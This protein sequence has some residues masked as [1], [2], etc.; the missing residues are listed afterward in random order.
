MAEPRDPLADILA[1]APPLKAGGDPLA[2]ILAAAPSLRPAPPLPPVSAPSI[3]PKAAPTAPPMMSST[4]DPFAPKQD[5]LPSKP[6]PAPQLKPST[7]AAPEDAVVPQAPGKIPQTV[8]MS[9]IGQT[10]APIPGKIP[11]MELL[12]GVAPGVPTKPR[13]IGEVSA[14]SLAG[15]MAG[16]FVR[17]AG[18]AAM[19]VPRVL[20]RIPGGFRDDLE[21][22]RPTPPNQEFIGAEAR[23]AEDA[24]NRQ[25]MARMI[26]RAE[27]SALPAAPLT[28]PGKFA[29]ALGSTAPYIAA[30]AVGGNAATGALGVAAGVDEAMTRADMSGKPI[31][32][33]QRAMIG[34]GGAAIGSTEALPFARL[35][36]KLKGAGVVAEA[37]DDAGIVKQLFPG[38]K[39]YLTSAGKQGLEEGAQEGFSNLAQDAMEASYGARA[40]EKIGQDFFENAGTGGAVGV[41]IDAL[42]TLAG[43]RA[44]R[45]R[46]RQSG[47]DP[48][49]FRAWAEQQNQ[50]KQ[51]AVADV[52]G[53]PVEAAQ[54][55]PA[56]AP[57]V[58][59]PEASPAVAPQPDPLQQAI[60]SAPPLPQ[61][62]KPEA[63]APV[64]PPVQQV[65]PPQPEAAV[66]EDKPTVQPS[67]NPGELP[68]APIPAPGPREEVVQPKPAEA[69]APVAEGTNRGLNI[70]KGRDLGVD[71]LHGTSPEGKAAIEESGIFDP[72]KA[73][74]HYDY[75]EFGFG[76]SYFAK[77]ESW[78]VQNPENGRAI[79]YK[80]SVEASLDPDANIVVLRNID[81]ADALARSFGFES[82]AKLYFGG[83]ALD[84]LRDFSRLKYGKGSTSSN[85]NFLSERYKI[86]QEW[87]RSK[88][89]TDRMV[90]AGI[91]G[92]YVE[93]SKA[94]YIGDPRYNNFPAGDQLAIF[95]PKAIRPKNA[96]PKEPNAPL[97]PEAPP[98]PGPVEAAAPQSTQEK[99][100]HWWNSKPEAERKKLLSVDGPYE[101]DESDYYNLNLKE[102]SAVE[103]LYEA[104]NPGSL[105]SLK[106]EKSKGSA[107]LYKRIM[108]HV[109][110]GGDVYIAGRK[111]NSDQI[112]AIQPTNDA[113]PAIKMWGKRTTGDYIQLPNERVAPP[114]PTPVEQTAPAP[115]QEVNPPKP[116]EFIGEDGIG[117]RRDSLFPTEEMAESFISDERL[118]TSLRDHHEFEIR[119]EDGGWRI[120]RRSASTG[121][122]HPWTYFVDGKPVW[123]N[124]KPYSTKATRLEERTWTS[125]APPAPTP[126]EA[127]ETANPWD[128]EPS[129]DWKPDRRLN[130]NPEPIAPEPVEADN[131]SAVVDRIT[132]G[133]KSVYEIADRLVDA[134][135]S[136]PRADVQ[137]AIKRRLRDLA[138]DESSQDQIGTQLLRAISFISAQKPIDADK[139]P[140]ANI[141]RSGE[142][143]STP[144]VEVADQSDAYRNRLFELKGRIRK[145]EIPTNREMSFLSDSDRAYIVR[146]GK[147]EGVEIPSRKLKS[148]GVPAV[149]PSAP[150][151]IKQSAPAPVQRDTAPESPGRVGEEPPTWAKAVKGVFGRR[152]PAK[153]A[154]GYKVDTQWGVVPLGSLR[155][156]NTD[157]GEINPEYP[158]QLQPRQRDRKSSDEQIQTIIEGFDPDQVAESYIATDGAPIVGEE[159]GAVES[160]NGRSMAIRRIYER[161]PDKANNYRQWMIDNADRFG[162]DA[163]AVSQIDRP[164]L[165]RIRRG[166]P[167][168]V[169]RAD[170]GR[171][172]NE[173]TTAGMS[174]AEQS[175]IDA[176]AMDSSVIEKFVPNE[177]G[178]I[179]TTAN[180]PFVN[181]FIEK[182]V[183]VS[184]RGTMRAGDGRL[185]TAGVRRI[186]NAIFAKAYNDRGMIERM[187]EDPDDNI[188]SVV[189][190]M[191]STAPRFISIKAAIEN[192]NLHDLDI[193]NDL[194]A[195]ASTLSRLRAEK[196]S[197]DDYLLQEDMFGRPEIQDAIL[198]T[199]RDLGRS[200]ARFGDILNQ[201]AD[202]VEAAGNP[203][204]VGMFGPTEVPTPL[205][206]WSS[207]VEREQADA[208]G[209]Q[210][211]AAPG[212]VDAGGTGVGE[213]SRKGSSKKARRSEGEQ[214]PAAPGPV[215]Q[216]AS[217]SRSPLGNTVEKTKD[218]LQETLVTDLEARESQIAAKNDRNRPIAEV[219]FSL[220]ADE[221]PAPTGPDE[222]QSSMFGDEVVGYAPKSAAFRPGTP[223]PA[224]GKA[225]KPQGGRKGQMTS[226]SEIV[227]N[228]SS[229]LNDIPI[230]TGGFRER[231]AGIFKV[232]QSVIRSK[233]ALDLPTIAHEIGHA[234]HKYLWG[235]TAK[236]NGRLN[237]RPLMP[238]RKELGALDYDPQKQR[239]FEGFAEY[240]RL[241]ITD[242][243]EATI[244]AP[245]FQAW[246]NQQLAQYPDLASVLDRAQEQY[247]NW[248]IQPGAVKIAA[249]INVKP[250]EETFWQRF[251][252]GA[253]SLQY[254]WVDDKIDIKN[255][256]DLFQKLGATVTD[257]ENAY[258][259]ARMVNGSFTRA[260][261]SLDSGRVNAKNEVE[262]PGLQQIL[263]P[264]ADRPES[265]RNPRFNRLAKDLNMQMANDGM[266]DLRLYIVAKRLQ[267]YVENRLETGFEKQWIDE[268]IRATE[269]PE[270]K[271]A[272]Q[273]IHD[274]SDGILQYLVDKGAMSKEAAAIIREKNEFYVPL[275]RVMDNESTKSLLGRKML[276]INSPVMRRKGSTREI[277]DPLESIVRNTYAMFSYAD[278]NAVAQ[279][280]VKQAAKVQDQGWLVESGVVRPMKRT[281]FNLKEVEKQIKE[282]LDDNGIDASGVDFDSMVAIYRQNTA[283]KRGDGIVSVVVDGTPQLFQMDKDLIRGLDSMSQGQVDLLWR[284]M[285]NA[286]GVLRF[287]ATAGN[288]E[289][290]LTNWFR[291]QFMAGLQSR[292]GYIPFLDGVAGAFTL[293]RNPE[294]VAEWRRNGGATAAMMPLTRDNL[295][296]SIDRMTMDRK[297]LLIRHPL[298]II[299][300]L[301]D[302]LTVMGSKSE[303]ATRI[304]EY[305]LARKR[306]KSA[307]EAAFDSRDVTLDFE[308][309]GHL[310]RFA[311][312]VIPFFSVS[313]NAA[314]R[315]SEMHDPRNPKMA[316]KAAALG[317]A[318]IT[319]PSLMLWWM[320]KDDEKYK[321]IE[322]WKRD[323]FWLIPTKGTG[324]ER[325]FGP[326]IRLPKPP[327]FGQMYGSSVER[328]A[329]S[330]YAKNPHAFDG[331]GKTLFDMWT[332]PVT[333]Q[334]YKPIQEVISNYN[335][336]TDRPIE[337]DAMKKRS[338]IYRYTPSTS[339]TAKAMSRAFGKFMENGPSPVQIEHLMLGYTAG[340]GRFAVTAAEELSGNRKDRP[341][342]GPADRPILRAFSTPR[343]P[344]FSTNYKLYS[345]ELRKLS[346]KQEDAK[347]TKDAANGLSSGD[348]SRLKELKALEKKLADLRSQQF[349]IAQDSKLG[350]QEKADQID[351]LYEK[352][353]KLLL[354][355]K[356]LFVK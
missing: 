290:V 132:N 195:A 90:E 46:M 329:D 337:T 137:A 312:R 339:E 303:E 57:P 235:T 71:W 42:T 93:P 200:K 244:R 182:V 325:T 202:A 261:M 123:K 224:K 228:L 221:A 344:F 315:F 92:V 164:V 272:A 262:G 317:F 222:R 88:Q 209:T 351:A 36:G 252:E 196:M 356:R 154:R 328:M 115:I 296:K 278:R 117:A 311:N 45:A 309:M 144:L 14:P 10:N 59:Q 83:L 21:A 338:A 251:K 17:G 223:T 145:G 150:T 47:V 212:P 263:K 291:D 56:P 330:L 313:I 265:Q 89:L 1:S 189:G 30:G 256:V 319:I 282:L 19:S 165:V 307:A 258:R 246:L 153:T 155:I 49:A 53:V 175:A 27:D 139:L 91:D 187:A 355:N 157:S 54:P 48:D 9:P 241:R 260:S 5:W 69:A 193:S 305:R 283:P 321:Q 350:R 7:L 152:S 127:A 159:D 348:A 160:G 2:D 277:I 43:S 94:E 134:F 128:A 299:T 62:A 28:V 64:P 347:F 280:L 332:P 162:L 161:F 140:I 247:R 206:I 168:G 170:F 240:I 253:G 225:P 111:L 352:R 16:G 39:E 269:T 302:V 248:D 6:K 116:G 266:D 147:A 180:A 75:T 79:R 87:K 3:T 66:A 183:P 281:E 287:G 213:G 322:D 255:A 238:F 349:R 274:Y 38:W 121:K 184:E 80:S 229:F 185:S 270:L 178:S 148:G 141:R 110:S 236:S 198:T 24:R 33:T 149:A 103:S 298:E 279:A 230:R 308:R 218:G 151:P 177:D 343:T 106:S 201:Y 257:V 294:M 242:P 20:S 192:G 108:D 107:D 254:N 50:E 105:A 197:I 199:L 232:R 176:K 55:A 95:N 342:M 293:L 276:D 113:Y 354:Q 31:T 72:T 136:E 120:Y 204:Q 118:G 346:Q 207:I 23:S 171:D 40:T 191:V 214:G 286:T 100:V 61:E 353:E 271:K 76:T 34:A 98:P 174:P 169:T 4:V 112:K 135:V 26:S 219:P 119:P 11:G 284:M 188:K 239:P 323:L 233:Q 306:G 340:L 124:P 264:I 97:S 52:L 285:S 186:Q 208:R 243:A 314:Q 82:W 13:P 324:L 60:E 336:F 130:L 320:N 341:A 304:G 288:P 295:R 190:A 234:I 67:G 44:G 125:D 8:E 102:Q 310:A 231:A 327:L 333:A 133:A 131:P 99:I 129:S 210:D 146:F 63:V 78:W 58:V 217:E 25:Q 37:A 227:N 122:Y 96:N 15:D 35:L 301:K 300:L 109:A 32:D 268:A 101:Y 205:G 226:R 166:M 51:R 167:E 173:R 172:A 86:Q 267:N 156:S 73:K 104:E 211:N 81:D 220:T 318:G 179:D 84:D 194:T 181:A 334:A 292:N 158:G 237:Q 138:D 143:F 259:L 68:P 331:F 215:E 203:K 65:A 18:S 70:V 114:A 22:L 126:V 316:A 250:T 289:F 216:R 77:P 74:R 335:E 41:F 245:H 163:N 275:Y 85:S 326:F 249:S 345:K 142:P 273:E 29:E 297:E 12:G